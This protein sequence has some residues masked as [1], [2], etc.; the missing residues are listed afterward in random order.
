MR[1]QALAADYD[2]TLASDGRIADSTAAMLRRVADTGRRL[3]LVT[4]RELPELM[5]ICPQLDLFNRV[6]A[7]NGALLYSPQTQQ[8]RA[9]AP[10]P[11]GEFIEE[12]KRRNVTPLSIGT[13]IV[14]TFYPHQDVVL[15]VI[16]ELGLQLQVI[17]NK[18]A[19]MVLPA[20]VDKASGLKAALL[21]LGLSGHNVVALGD[22]ENDHA[23]LSSVGYSVA[24]GNAVPMLKKFAYRNVDAAAGAGCEQIMAE[25]IA[26]DLGDKGAA[27]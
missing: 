21:E 9:L 26:N 3:V 27:R 17:F 7:E 4:G 23:L 25:L 2:G 22:G 12:L 16:R 11:P 8:S 24:V 14:A 19:V 10:P 5:H 6:V 15:D 20:G 18:G 13:C 1:Y